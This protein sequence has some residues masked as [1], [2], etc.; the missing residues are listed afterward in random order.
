MTEHK[1]FWEV[2][3]EQKE[4]HFNRHFFDGCIEEGYEAFREC[5]KYLG[6]PVKISLVYDEDSPKGR[7]I[8]Y[9]KEVL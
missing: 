7:I 2:E 6:I 9:K 8:F 1:G 5:F 3:E 4:Y